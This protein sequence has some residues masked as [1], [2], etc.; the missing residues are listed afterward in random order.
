[1]RALYGFLFALGLALAPAVAAGQ[2]GAGVQQD[3]VDDD[4]FVT[5]RS[6]E[7]GAAI[8]GDLFVAGGWVDVRAEVEDNVVAA[9]GV[10][11]I[12]GSAGS[13]VLAAAAM[14]D[15][16]AAIGEN[17]VAAGGI[18]RVDGPVAGKLFAGAAR[19]RLGRPA[20]IQGKAW[21]AGGSIEVAGTIR[22]D[23]VIG[24]G[25]VLVRGR[26]EGDLEV[27]ALS[28]E[29]TDGA[30]VGGR[31]V[32]YGPDPPTIAEGAV[33]EG[34]VVHEYEP[35]A[36]DEPAEAAGPPI[37]WLLIT[38]GLGL[39]LDFTLPR[40]VRSASARLGSH[41][42]ACFGLGLS[43]LVVTPVVILILIISILGIAIGIAAIAAYGTLLLLGPVIA[44]FAATDLIVGRLWPAATRTPA[45]RR[46]AFI[47]TLAAIGLLGWVPY[48][49]T[50]LLWLMTV[51]GLGGSSWQLYE[52][53]RA[54]PAGVRADTGAGA[55]P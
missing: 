3:L 6:V 1:M 54:E 24:A 36:E 52:S 40:Y 38:L 46:L 27:T 14:L 19:I 16:S 22:N 10:A 47:G 51:L 49:G 34:E 39:L 23:A 37:F 26:I 25:R 30:H 44:L 9:G 31:L 17:L 55:S 48:V 42:F 18:V 15:V 8:A 12:A 29:L 41:P 35:R 33:V 7:V 50:P 4:L 13:D 21:L 20:A 28:L 11:D 5:G 43:V 53:V 2:E 45:R 32:Y